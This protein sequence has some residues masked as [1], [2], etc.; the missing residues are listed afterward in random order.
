MRP[1]IIARTTTATID[2]GHDVDAF[3]DVRPAPDGTGGE[4]RRARE[5]TGKDLVGVFSEGTFSRGWTGDDG[6]F[7][8]CWIEGGGGGRRRAEGKQKGQGSK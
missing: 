1:L 8:S 3:P 5:A 6:H 4:G 2:I 7:V